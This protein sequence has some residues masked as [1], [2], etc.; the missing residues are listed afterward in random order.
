M[1]ECVKSSFTGGSI[2]FSFLWKLSIKMATVQINLQ[3]SHNSSR[4]ILGKVKKQ[5]VNLW[6]LCFLWIMKMNS[7][8]FMR[9]KGHGKPHI[10]T[11]Y[12][13]TRKHLAHNQTTMIVPALTEIGK[14][15][16]ECFIIGFKLYQWTMTLHFNPTRILVTL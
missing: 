16:H 13:N 10:N 1:V 8:Q 7:L 6:M 15:G 5:A 4:N 3:E 14:N 11:Y 2:F 12:V 9:G